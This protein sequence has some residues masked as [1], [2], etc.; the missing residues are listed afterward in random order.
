MTTTDNT[1]TN[2][3]PTTGTGADD[4][5]DSKTYDA[6]YVRKLRDEAA[7]HRQRATTAEAQLDELKNFRLTAMLKEHAGPILADPGDLS[8]FGK[9][10]DIYDDEG[11]PDA[12]KIKT[13]AEGLVNEKPHLRLPPKPQGNV[14]QGARETAQ[15]PDSGVDAFAAAIRGSA[16]G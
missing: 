1:G 14:D 8:V 6:G 16:G 5:D 7:Q 2:P 10:D 13:V 4:I 12:E 9:L 11:R 15:T 3:D